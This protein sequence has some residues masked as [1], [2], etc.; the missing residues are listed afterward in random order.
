VR[1]FGEIPSLVIVSVAEQDAKRVLLAAR[2]ANVPAEKLGVTGGD[3]LV[4]D[5][6][7]RANPYV[8]TCLA[9]VEHGKNVS[10]PS[11]AGSPSRNAP[12]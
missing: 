9:F 11:S 1:F 7:A 12:W 4:L 3:A 2:E 6:A 10:R 5:D 8:W